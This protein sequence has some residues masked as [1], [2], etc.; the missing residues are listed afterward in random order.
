MPAKHGQSTVVTQGNYININCLRRLLCI[1]WQNMI[2]DTEVLKC[3]GLQGIHAL[4]K[5]AQLRW[6]G[7]VVRMS[8]ERLP[9]RVLYGEQ[10]EG[11][12]TVKTPSN[13]PQRPLKSTTSV[14]K[15]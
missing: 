2:P 10:S 15:A 4:L 1:T 5:T 6:T 12:P 3:A 9:K 7:H 11:R 13:P 8:Y 14:E